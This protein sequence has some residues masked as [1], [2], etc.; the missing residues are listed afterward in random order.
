MPFDP[1]KKWNIATESIRPGRRGYRV[2]G[3]FAG[4]PFQSFIVARSKRFWV[5]VEEKY[6]KISRVSVGDTV[7]IAIEPDIN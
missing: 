7:T 4:A 3:V 2:H 5:L 1:A 6:L